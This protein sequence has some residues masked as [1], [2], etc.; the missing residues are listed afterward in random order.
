M[1]ALAAVMDE[2]RLEAH[3]LVMGGVKANLGHLE[4]G[5]GA[6]GLIKAVMVLQHETATPNPELKSLN[7]KVAAV[8]E[9]FPVRFPIELEP[10]R[11]YSG[12]VEDKEAL[13]AGVSSFGAYG[14]IAHAV[15][16][17]ARVGMEREIA[18][19]GSAELGET[20]QESALLF[21]FTGQGSQYVDM[22]Q[23]LYKNEP[24]F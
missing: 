1:N 4:A 23:V 8:V 18:L 16:S 6:A 13:V 24:V 19:P 2:D 21:V 7:P 12:K 10:L 3:P 17:Q 15:I 9:G 14:T 20:L 5:A 11:Q 22:G